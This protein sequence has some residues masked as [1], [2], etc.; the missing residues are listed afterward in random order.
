[1]CACL[2]VWGGGG[3]KLSSRKSEVSAENGIF[4]FEM[5]SGGLDC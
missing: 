1:M 5:I 2:S 4:S 3:V